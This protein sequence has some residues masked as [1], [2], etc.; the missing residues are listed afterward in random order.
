MA[1]FYS[2]GVVF[3]V[4]VGA[5][6]LV[7]LWRVLSGQMREEELVMVKESEEQAELEALQEE[8]AREEVAFDSHAARRSK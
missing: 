2:A 7:D 5:I 3:A 1:I 8:I 4:S 6:L